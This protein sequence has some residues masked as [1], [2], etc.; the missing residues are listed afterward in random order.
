MAEYE[1]IPSWKRPPARK[2]WTRCWTNFFPMA[3]NH[4]IASPFQ[5]A[6]DDIG[7][8]ESAG[9]DFS[10]QVLTEHF[11]RG[12]QLL[13]DNELSPALPEEAFKILQPQ[14]AAAVAG[15]LQS[16][17]YLAGRALRAALFPKSRSGATGNH[18]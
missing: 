8:I 7:A 13:A 15:E 3:P 14:L 10:L 6:L 11:E 5:K 18:A 9:T 4:W 12:V 16:P 1:T 2:A 17:D